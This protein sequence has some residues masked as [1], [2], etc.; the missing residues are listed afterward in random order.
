M[1]LV[2]VGVV[3]GLAAAIGASRFLSTLLFGLSPDDVMTI[4]AAT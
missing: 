3:I 2:A 1:I 4:A